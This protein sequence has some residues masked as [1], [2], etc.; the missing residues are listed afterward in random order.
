MYF[1]MT[2][3]VADIELKA[4]NHRGPN[5]KNLNLLWSLS[6]KNIFAKEAFLFVAEVYNV[7]LFMRKQCIHAQTS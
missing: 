2:T 1:Y 6:I 4:K 3:P 7:F 5:A